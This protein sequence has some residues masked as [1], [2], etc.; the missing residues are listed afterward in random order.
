VAAA[1]VEAE[2]A[3]PARVAILLAAILSKFTVARPAQRPVCAASMPAAR[4]AVARE[5]IGAGPAPTS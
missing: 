3:R 5:P 4:R 2:V 1:A